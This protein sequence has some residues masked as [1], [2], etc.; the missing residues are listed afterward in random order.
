MF[1]PVSGPCRDRCSFINLLLKCF[2]LYQ[3]LTRQVLINN[4]CNSNAFRYCMRNKYTNYE[5]YSADVVIACKNINS[6]VPL[7]TLYR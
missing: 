6:T 2:Y 5:N 3:V 7:G 1:L 4:M